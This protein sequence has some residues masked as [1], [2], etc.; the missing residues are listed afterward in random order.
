MKID[1]EYIKVKIPVCIINKLKN[2]YKGNKNDLMEVELVNYN[3]GE[4]N[5]VALL[6]K[7]YENKDSQYG[8]YYTKRKEL[9]KYLETGEI[10]KMEDMKFKYYYRVEYV[11]RNLAKN[12]SSNKVYNIGDFL[13]IT[14]DS[15][16]Y[17]IVKI[18]KIY[19]E[20]DLN[21][22]NL[23]T[24]VIDRRIVCKIEDD[25]GKKLEELN[26][27]QLEIK[28]INK[29]IM[30]KYLLL[31]L[32]NEIT[33]ELEKIKNDLKNLLAKEVVLKEELEKYE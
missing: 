1:D 18:N 19:S 20:E 31:L 29:M 10:E 13:V 22:I 2:E 16:D 4:Y 30:D 6:I 26:D 27:I 17:A 25:Y 33:P 21:N 24:R 12:I 32:N 11:E 14:S 7:G 15:S 28:A 9:D 23:D 5:S 3:Q 8:Y